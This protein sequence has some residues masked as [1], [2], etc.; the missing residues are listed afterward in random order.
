MT[1]K[2]LCTAISSAIALMASGAALAQNDDHDRKDYESADSYQH[3]RALNEGERQDHNEGDRQDKDMSVDHHPMADYDEGAS[4]TM[5]GTVSDVD[6]GDF[7]LRTRHGMVEVDGDDIFD[8]DNA[9][10]LANGDQVTVSGTVDDDLFESREIDA[11]SVHVDKVDVTFTTQNDPVDG[12]TQNTNRSAEHGGEL[13]GRVL[14]IGDGEFSIASGG[15][16]VTVDVDELANNPLDDEGFPILEV[17]DRV[18]VSGEMD[19]GWFEDR[20]FEA[21]ALNIIR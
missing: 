17:G 16:T 14:S 5:Q 13:S 12:Y 10:Q 15:G 19:D 7:T 20:E 4:I 6:D 2:R 8:D 3:E 9:F 11:R 18:R 1:K 21:V